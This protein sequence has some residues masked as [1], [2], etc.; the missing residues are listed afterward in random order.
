MALPGPPKKLE[1][2]KNRSPARPGPMGPRAQGPMGP[3]PGRAGG[4]FFV[5]FFNLLGDPGRAI[6]GIS[7]KFAARGANR[8][9]IWSRER[10]NQANLENPGFP[11]QVASGV[12]C[13]DK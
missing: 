6:F 10:S 7:W 13:S 4:R 3:G 2:N 8:R 5:L 11:A 1:E 12:F 9:L